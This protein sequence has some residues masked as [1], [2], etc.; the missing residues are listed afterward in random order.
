MKRTDHFDGASKE[1]TLPLPHIWLL[2]HVVTENVCSQELR[3]RLESER[4]G[5]NNIIEKW[6]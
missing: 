2:P 5:N 3:L 1:L 6:C 4:E